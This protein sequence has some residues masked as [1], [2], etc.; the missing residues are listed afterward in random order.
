M[1]AIYHYCSVDVMYSIIS[2]KCIR[3]SDLNKTN[4]YMEKKWALNIFY[5]ALNEELIDQGITVDLSEKC[6]YKEGINTH[7]EYLVNFVKEYVFCSNPILIAC[8]SKKGDKLSQWRAYGDDGYGVSIGFNYDKL[9]Q[10]ETGNIKIKNVIYQ[11][12]KQKKEIKKYIRLSISHMKKLFK[13]WPVKIFND[14]NEYFIEEFDAFCEVLVD[15]MDYVSCY[16]KN[17]AFAEEEEVRIIYSPYIDVEMDDKDIKR[18][19]H[20]TTKVGR[21]CLDSVKYYIKNKQ[22]VAYADLYFDKLIDDN[23]ILEI[24]LGPKSKLTENDVFLFLLSNDF[25]AD[26]IKISR[27]TATYR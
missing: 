11:K 22:L 2:N 17:P 4:D 15:Y 24:I 10:L 26:K 27:S 9:Q 19:F 1:S 6:F 16:I 20:Q 13:D 25:N 7:L 8:F 12:A 23:I 3:L 14:F 21:Y 5:D 18:Y